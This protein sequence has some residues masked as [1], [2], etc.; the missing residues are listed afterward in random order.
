MY[1]DDAVTSQQT[2]NT[3]NCKR[4]YVK[5]KSLKKPEELKK[6]EFL[7]HTAIEKKI[8][9]CSLC[10]DLPDSDSVQLPKCLCYFCKKCFFKFLDKNATHKAVLK[11]SNV[12]LNPAHYG[13]SKKSFFEYVKNNKKVFG[14]IFDVNSL[15]FDGSVLPKQSK[16]RIITKV[17]DFE[18]RRPM[19]KSPIKTISYQLVKLEVFECPNCFAFY[20]DINRTNVHRFRVVGDILELMNKK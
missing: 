19:R 13:K 9:I 4:D 7:S 5:V 3:S 12:S 2:A 14:G 17:S 20:D 11:E 6:D 15:S 18:E 16:P 8:G 10:Q 1:E